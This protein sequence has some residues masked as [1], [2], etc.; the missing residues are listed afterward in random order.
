MNPK[1]KLREWLWAPLLIFAA[2]LSGLYTAPHAKADGYLSPGEADYVNNYGYIICDTI[3]T[4]PTATGVLG[5]VKGVM[6]TGG[7]TAD[8]AVDV[9][10]ASVQGQCDEWWPLLQRIGRQ[11]R[12]EMTV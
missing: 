8:N 11:A 12:G 10:N 3:A 4:R 7:F 6:T 9:V 5:V 1:P 2:I